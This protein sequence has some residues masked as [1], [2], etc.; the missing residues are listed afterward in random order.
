[1]AIDYTPFKSFEPA[2]A[3]RFVL[4]STKLGN[5]A[6]YLCKAAG[7]PK[8]DQGEV[9]IDYINT[10]FKVKGKSRWQDI[11]VTMYDPIDN[12]EGT[13]A[14]HE[15]IK[16]H[17]NSQTAV[18]GYAFTQYKEDI[19]IEVL[20]PAGSVMQ[21]WTLYGAFI[22]AVDWGSMDWSTD[23]AKTIA[24]TIKYDYAVL[25]FKSYNG[26]ETLSE[27]YVHR[28]GANIASLIFSTNNGST[29]SE[30]MRIA[31]S[32]NLLIGTTTDD[33][34]NKLQVSGSARVDGVLTANSALSDI[35]GTF[36]L[37]MNGGYTGLRTG[38][39]GSFNVDVYKSGTGYINPFKIKRVPH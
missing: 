24:L 27:I 14:V 25:T 10:D 8:I 21:T 39:D 3:F 17:H 1:M 23:E 7:L 18:D 38:T 22:S 32:G 28:T 19:K 9:V 15:W 29:A 13:T 12:E 11:T 33:G 16:Q 34:V 37:V 26:S 5:G 20:D 35:A 2:V 36:A 6:P 30:R 4:R 31:A